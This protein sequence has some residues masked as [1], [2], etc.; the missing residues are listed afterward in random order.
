M[1]NNDFLYT[2]FPFLYVVITI[3]IYLYELDILLTYCYV[4]LKLSCFLEIL[5][6]NMEQIKVLLKDSTSEQRA[7]TICSNAIMQPF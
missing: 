2:S 5:V 3:H 4:I 6:V 7:S 1:D